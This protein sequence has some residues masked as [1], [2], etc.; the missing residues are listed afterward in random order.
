MGRKTEII[1]INYDYVPNIDAACRL[2]REIDKKEINHKPRKVDKPLVL[3]G[4]GNLGRMAAD[5]FRKIGVNIQFVV[6]VNPFV[7]RDDIFWEGIPIVSPEEVSSTDKS[8]VLLAVCI[9]TLA[10]TPIFKSLIEQG[11]DDIIPFYD[12]AEAYR[13]HHPLSNGWFLEKMA[14]KDIAQIEWVIARWFDDI[15][16]A[17]HLQFLAWRSLREEWFFSGAPVTLDD[18]YFIKTVKDILHDHETFLDIGAHHGEVSIRFSIITDGKFNKIFAIEPDDQNRK[19]LRIN[20]ADCFDPDDK[21]KVHVLN[22]VIGENECIC[23]MYDG[24]DYA[25]QVCEFGEKT[26]NVHTIDKMGILPTFI[27]LHLEGGELSALKGG[28]QTIRKTRPI[29]V[30]TTYHNKL[31]LWEFPQWIMNSLIDYRFYMRLHGWC[32]TG[33][34]VYAIPLERV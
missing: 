34:V 18:R 7:H 13:D 3:Y 16:R 24:L 6:D 25:S 33:L 5:Y 2:V 4:A 17:H 31:G 14:Q 22:N 1:A 28:I 29:I 10:L 9:S 19:L 11:W 8:S 12:I 15:S 30:A 32:G 26:V 20:F 27:K 23:K 21:N